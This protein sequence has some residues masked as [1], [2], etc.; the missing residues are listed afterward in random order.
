MRFS[1]KVNDGIDV[2]LK[3]QAVNQRS[4]ANVALDKNMP[5]GIR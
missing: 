4:I 3:Q 2:V 1:R 5:F